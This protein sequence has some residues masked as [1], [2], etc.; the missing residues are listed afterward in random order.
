MPK[1][2]RPTIRRAALGA[3]LVLAAA[4]QAAPADYTC[5]G[6]T[7]LRADFSPR[8]AQLRHEGQ[9]WSLQ[10]VRGS[11]EAH[12]VSGTAG[13]SVK[14]RGNQATLARKGQPPLA[15]KLV[16]QALR[17]EA[18]GIAPAGSGTPAPR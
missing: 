9:Q 15:C 11:R 5:E 18:L 2:P 8:A 4:A 16:V 13:V 10:R 3:L 6:G 7:T 12:Y 1:T 14:V 17:P